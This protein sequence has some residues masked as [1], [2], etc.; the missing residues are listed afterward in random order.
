MRPVTGTK[1]RTPRAGLVKRLLRSWTEGSQ[2]SPL[3]VHPVTPLF[4]VMAFKLCYFTTKPR[5]VNG[6]G[7]FFAAFSLS[8]SPEKHSPPPHTSGRCSPD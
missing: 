4:F 8:F 1:R 3:S 2:R 5:F 6:Q 7:R